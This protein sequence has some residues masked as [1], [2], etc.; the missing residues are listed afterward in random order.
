MEHS[1]RFTIRSATVVIP[2][3]FALAAASAAFAKKDWPPFGHD[4]AGTRYSTPK[5]IDARNV[6]KLVSVWTYH[7]DADAAL[8]PSVR[9][10]R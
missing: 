10:Q 4:L 2:F 3:V 1:S 6:A 8:C 5:Q 7:M 9:G